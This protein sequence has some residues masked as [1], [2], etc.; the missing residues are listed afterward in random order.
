MTDR[1]RDG[2]DEGG[3][4]GAPATGRRAVTSYAVARAANVS[5]STV[6]L[7]LSGKAAGRVSAA[8]QALVI[9]TARR[10][11]Y[12]KNEMARVLRTGA[13]RMLALAVPNVQQPFFGQIL[14]AAE[15][16]ARENDH[17]VVLIDT[18]TDPGWIERLLGMF[19]GGLIAGCIVYASDAA[20]EAALAAV[21]DRVLFVEAENPRQSGIDLDVAGGLA[22]AV[23][24]L[25]ALGHRRIGYF[26]ADYPKATYRRR[27]D[28]FRAAVKRHGLKHDRAWRAAATFEI[29][30]ATAAA[31]ALLAPLP[32]TALFCDDDL[33]AA[34]TYRAARGLGIAIPAALSVVGFNDIELARMLAPELTTVA[35]PAEAIGRLAVTRLITQIDARGAAA[36]APF[37]LA[38]DLRARGS[39]AAAPGA[40]PGAGPGAR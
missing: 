38:L 21:R 8:T 27:F 6:S 20:T 22:Q 12:Q 24:H 35:I 34:A 17:A 31:A 18:T 23:A 2:D 33:L 28:A 7:V 36:E 30:R 15:L 4:I 10:F 25:A 40:A 26:A 3:E 14:V 19:G 5:Q 11:G 29:D 13:S 37:V 9:E 32:F 16:A 39:T 1:E